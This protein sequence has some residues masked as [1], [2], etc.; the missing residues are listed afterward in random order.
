MPVQCRRRGPR[1]RPRL[2]VSRPGP[3]RVALAVG[4]RGRESALPR[5]EPTGLRPYERSARAEARGNP[6]AS[7]YRPAPMAVATQREYGLFINGESAE[8][9]GGEAREL[10]EPATGEPLATV[11]VAAEV[12]V[13]RAVDAARAALD[14]D[15]GK[16]P[17][18]ERSGL[19]R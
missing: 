3:H 14:G 17:P 7:R 18:N 15:W 4:G 10:S 11:A 19:P 8:P 12:D 13:E 9:A 16:T 2:R 6:P 5:P 1:C